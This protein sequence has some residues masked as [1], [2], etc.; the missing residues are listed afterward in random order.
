MTQA[1]AP[2]AGTLDDVGFFAPRIP[3]RLVNEI[4]RLAGKP[5]RSAEIC[6]LVGETAEHLGY[7]RPSYEQVR[8]LVKQARHAPMKLSTAEVLLDIG[9][10]S[11]HPNALVGHVSGVNTLYRSK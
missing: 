10:R 9:L 7:R 11:R 1:R 5:Y 6:R 4:E 2:L 3:F 8:L